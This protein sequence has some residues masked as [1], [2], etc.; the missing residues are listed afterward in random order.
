MVGN[1][2]NAERAEAIPARSVSPSLTERPDR[3]KPADGEKAQ[4]SRFS[5]TPHRLF[6]LPPLRLISAFRAEPGLFRGG[7][8]PLRSNERG[9]HVIETAV[10]SCLV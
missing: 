4:T 8:W 3:V 7:P 5:G 10:T 6:G 1:K 9:D 2:Q